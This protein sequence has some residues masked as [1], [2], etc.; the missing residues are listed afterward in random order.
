MK[1][2]GILGG[3]QLGQMM[4]Q[5]AI[6]LNIQIYGI[7]PNDK[8]SLAQIL[9]SDQFTCA[10]LTNEE[11]IKNISEKVDVITFETEHIN[12]DCINN[13]ITQPDLDT[14]KIIQNKYIQHLHFKNNNIQTVDFY[15]CINIENIKN[16]DLPI[17][18][19]CKNYSYDGLGNHVIY[20]INDIDIA[21]E[22]LKDR[23]S[24]FYIEKICNFD[25]E[26]SVIVARDINGK[27]E[28]YPTVE[29][30][31]E[32]SILI[33]TIVPARISSIIRTA[34]SNI[35][36]K[37]VD[38]LK[39]AGVFCV[40][41]F[42]KGNDIFVNEVAPRPHNSGHYT[43]EACYCSQFE[44]HLRAVSGLPLGST[45]MKVPAAVMVNILADGSCLNDIKNKTLNE[46]KASYHWYGKSERPFR[47]MGHVT[48]VGE[49]ILIC[50]QI[51][52]NIFPNNE[53]FWERTFDAPP[54][55]GIIMGS[56]SDKPKME[57]AMS[58]LRYHGIPFEMTIVSAHRTPIR[59]VAYANGARSRGLKCIIAAAG[60]AAHLPGMTASLTSLPVIGVPIALEHM[61]GM[62]S[63][64]SIVQMP[65][66]IPVATVA[67]DGAANAA[68]LAIRILSKESCVR[69]HIAEL[70]DQVSCDII[71]HSS[72]FNGN[73]DVPFKDI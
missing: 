71:K 54:I 42:L 64:L 55:V 6:S 17:I 23:K 4:A 68:H 30:I 35:A 51:I 36:L 49:D 39:G 34:A 25:K 38:S 56:A 59:L 9:P 53:M 32:N 26:L 50:R 24:D 7:D 14:L 41:M 8:C 46:P 60:G 37:V 47:K 61:K 20:N 16:F 13:I 62:D 66:G 31:H 27:T 63:L 69:E 67:I 3:G 10:P 28:C 5:A 72:A 70:N 45:D 43:I 1:Q 11:E 48:V 29:N 19:K 15:D 18:L 44:Q 22:K 21:Y 57:G 33:S 73:S 65:K 52:N 58:V 12:I 2:I 40:E